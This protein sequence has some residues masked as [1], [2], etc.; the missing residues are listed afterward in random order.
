MNTLMFDP[1]RHWEI[2]R[3][4]Y[5]QALDLTV[6]EASKNLE[7]SRKNLSSILNERTGISAEMAV[8]LSKAFGTSLDLWMGMQMEYEL[9][10]A[11][12]NADNIEVEKIEVK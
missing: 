6:T 12:K 9:A 3:E 8:N 11:L 10:A 5:L 2:L 1:P 7:V 4:D